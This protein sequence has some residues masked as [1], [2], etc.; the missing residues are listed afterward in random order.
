MNEQLMELLKTLGLVTIVSSTIVSGLVYIGKVIFNKGVD[1]YIESYRANLNKDIESHKNELLMET[2]KFKTDLSKMTFEH[3]IKFSKL[4]EERAMVI[5]E[6]SSRI[7]NL[8]KDLAHLTSIFQ[9]GGWVDDTGR[10]EKA[11]KSFEEFKDFFEINQ[12]YLEDSICFKVQA[13]ISDSLKIILGMRSA[14]RVA[15]NNDILAQK[16][17]TLP[18]A[19]LVFPG[20]TWDVMSKKV[21]EDYN[22]ARSELANEFK[23]I[24][25][26]QSEL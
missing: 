17:Q 16:G 20:D 4:H 25:G 18:E 15:K 8:H 23:K 19:K 1:A 26:I 7:Y 21:E 3:Q 24:I 14:K 9:G 5:K 6:I 10:D 2:E 22:I 12:I 13:L 11:I